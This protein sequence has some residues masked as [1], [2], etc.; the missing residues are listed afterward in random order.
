M[1]A[2]EVAILRIE[3]A[4]IEPLIWRRVAVRATSSLNTLHRIIQV[5]MGWLDYHLWEFDIDDVTYGVPD[6]EGNDWGRVIKPASRT[7]LAKVLNSGLDQFSYTYDIGDN[8]LHRIF[9]ER[10]EPADPNVIYPC[11]LGG[12]R[13]C[14]PEDC[15]SVPGYYEFIDAI[16]APDKGKGSRKK[17]EMLSWYGRPYD[18]D[19]IEE[20]RIKAELARMAY[21]PR[22]RKPADE[23][24]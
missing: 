10:I 15:G 18:P 17:R 19:D 5:T 23:R 7:K 6:P 9:V 16:S 14:P 24:S 4:D 2:D 1:S 3:L 21:Q 12:Q 8:W 22:R 11:F 13:R 20:N